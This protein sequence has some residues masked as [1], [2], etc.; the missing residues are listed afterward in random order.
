MGSQILQLLRRFRNPFCAYPAVV[1][2]PN[3][4]AIGQR[5]KSEC[6]L[7]SEKRK[8]SGQMGRFGQR[9][10]CTM[11]ASAGT[12]RRTQVPLN[13]VERLLFPSLN[14]LGFCESQV[15]WGRVFAPVR[16]AR[17]GSQRCQVLLGQA[18]CRTISLLRFRGMM[19]AELHFAQGGIKNLREKIIG[20]LPDLILY[21]SQAV[22]SSVERALTGLQLGG[23]DFAPETVGPCS[24]GLRGESV[25][26][27]G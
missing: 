1:I 7:V 9:L 14:Q 10:R 6:R 24:L 20:E 11:A 22:E 26:P 5:P 17:L 27:S 19:T 13:H 8:L 16:S 15:Y 23:Q 18:Q 2:D 12:L 4:E 25:E 3:S 21:A